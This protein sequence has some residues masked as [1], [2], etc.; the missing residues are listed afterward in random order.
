MNVWTKI[1][2]KVNMKITTI[3]RKV[4]TLKGSR[5]LKLLCDTSAM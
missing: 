4:A 2:E 3:A 1:L 5:K